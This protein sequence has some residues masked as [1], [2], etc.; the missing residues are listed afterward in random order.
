MHERGTQLNGDFV[1]FL[2][3]RKILKSL[4][5]VPVLARLGIIG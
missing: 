4:G 3:G 1:D 2:N 5:I